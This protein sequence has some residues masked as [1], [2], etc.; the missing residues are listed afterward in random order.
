MKRLGIAVSALSSGLVIDTSTN[1]AVTTSL[2]YLNYPL[3]IYGRDYGMDLTY[4]PLSDLDVI[5]GM[6]WLEFN[7]VHINCYNKSVRFLTR[8]DEEEASFISSS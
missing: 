4:L 7:H 6:N 3:S 2:I 8:D 5:L 1:G